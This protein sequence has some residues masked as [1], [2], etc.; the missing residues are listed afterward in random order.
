MKRGKMIHVVT[1]SFSPHMM[2]TARQGLFALISGNHLSGKI[3]E[4]QLTEKKLLHTCRWHNIITPQNRI[5]FFFAINI[6]FK[7]PKPYH[8][9][10]YFFL[11]HRLRFEWSNAD[12]EAN[13]RSNT[14][15]METTRWVVSHFKT[16]WSFL[17]R[18]C[19]QNSANRGGIRIVDGNVWNQFLMGWNVFKPILRNQTVVYKL[20]WTTDSRLN[21]IRIQR[22][23]TEWK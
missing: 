23:E 1:S 6:K 13:N 8:Q 3:V 17:D 9:I 2:G 14:H 5:L 11:V 10:L 20:S 22:A 12:D 16:I 19:K 21:I 7:H 18:F 4:K 15:V